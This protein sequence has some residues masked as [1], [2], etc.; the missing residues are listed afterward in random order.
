MLIDPLLLIGERDVI[1]LMP[2]DHGGR[3]TVAQSEREPLELSG[4]R[5]P[6]S[7][8][9]NLA[10]T[11]LYV[12]YSLDS[13]R[14]GDFAAIATYLGIENTSDKGSLAYVIAYRRA[15]VP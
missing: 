15:L 10:S 8:G 11:Y 3:L 12:P 13:S 4:G 9:Q 7:Q 14:A 1:G 5:F 6:Q 2:F